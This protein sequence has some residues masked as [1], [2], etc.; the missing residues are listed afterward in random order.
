MPRAERDERNMGAAGANTAFAAD[1][2]FSF[3]GGKAGPL[4]ESPADEVARGFSSKW[5]IR[6]R[7]PSGCG[8][9]TARVAFDQ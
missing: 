1:Q 5:M 9:P 2:V 6:S 4:I 7:R 3:P 8:G